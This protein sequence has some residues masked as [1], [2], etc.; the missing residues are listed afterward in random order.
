MSNPKLLLLD[1]PSMGLAPNLV[2]LV[3]ET[4]QEIHQKQDIPVLLVEQ[5][6]EMTLS[7]AHYA[8][9]LEVG[10]LV[11]EGTGNELLH[12]QEVRKKYL[13]A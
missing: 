7:I 6:A 5:N 9:V 1:E 13:G 8:Y 2:E 3:L 12:S 4:V 11:L 10:K